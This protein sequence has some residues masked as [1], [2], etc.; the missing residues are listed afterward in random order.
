MRRVTRTRV[1]RASRWTL[2]LAG[3]VALATPLAR[4]EEGEPP[5]GEDPFREIREQMEKISRL[6]RENEALLLE[7]SRVGGEAPAP[8]SVDPPPAPRTPDE[9]AAT[10]EKGARESDGPDASANGEEI[11]RRL[12]KL[13][14]GSSERGVAIPKEL[15]ELVRM[16]PT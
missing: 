9:K 1:V 3:I 8:V 11:R 2:A 5:S 14:R 15:E 13:I 6:M 16:W 7:A 12:E 10:D 4:A